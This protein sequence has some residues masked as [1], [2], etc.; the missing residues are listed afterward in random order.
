MLLKGK[1]RLFA[2]LLI[3]LCLTACAAQTAPEPAPAAQSEET[4]VPAPEQPEAPQP[5]SLAEVQ[6]QVAY[7]PHAAYM[8]GQNGYFF[9][10]RE[11]TRAEAARVLVYVFD[12][13]A[14]AQVEFTD[15]AA[16]S[17]FYPCVTAAENLLP[18]DEDGAFR[19]YDAVTLLE[20]ATAI[21]RGTGCRLPVGSAAEVLPDAAIRYAARFGWI[22]ADADGE[23]SVTRAQA[24]QILNR[25]L[26][27]TP[28]RA[29]IDA[30]D[31]RVF[32][33][34]AP[35][36][37]AYYEIMEAALAHSF[38]ESD[39]GAEVWSSDSISFVPLAPGLHMAGQ[40][41]L[42][43]LD[44]G[45]ILTE[46]G[47]FTEGRLT[48]LV[49][50][51]GGQ[52]YADEA[53]HLVGDQV[54]FCKR[55][56]TILKN[57]RRYD[58]YFDESGAYTTGDA[59]LDEL[60][61]AAVAACTTQDMTQE[62]KLRACYEY[63]RDFKYLGRN[64]ALPRTV[65]TMPHENAVEYARKIFE[66]GKGD[67]YNFAASFCFLARALGYEATAIVG[68]CGYAWSYS[69]IAHGWVE[70][71]MDGQTYLFDPQIENYNLRAGIDNETHSAYCVSYENA[72]G[73]YYK[74]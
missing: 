31:A 29:A 23:Q 46:P 3:A 2:L 5:E 22:D 71:V 41:A 44:D 61:D 68:A 42:Y 70:I 30:L 33:D 74:N 56:G 51:Q 45:S 1:T 10:D 69:A 64:A 73:R 4:L 36:H 25:A 14:D 39:D 21:C 37:A 55:D 19:P 67:C 59:S 63:V 43:V 66:T 50:E 60:V 13:P 12:T 57:A 49:S 16:D 17:W 26:G 28:D 18:G 52:I 72:P 54:V 38:P 48:Y 20:F 58:Y 53:L 7:T 35:D 47:L 32:L 9:P 24:V 6:P 40:N 62:Q 8:F 27:R 15:V 65:K 11:L 34:V